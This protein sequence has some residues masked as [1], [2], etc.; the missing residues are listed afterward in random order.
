MN[1]LYDLFHII[2]FVDG[3]CVNFLKRISPSS[4]AFPWSVKKNKVSKIL[5]LSPKQVKMVIIQILFLPF[6]FCT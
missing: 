5:G 6:L 2:F 3:H 1:V 4:I